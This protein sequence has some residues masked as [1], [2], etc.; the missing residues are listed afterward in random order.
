MFDTQ[1]VSETDRRHNFLTPETE[2][3]TKF[4]VG[5][6]V[7]P[8]RVRQAHSGSK[9]PLTSQNVNAKQSTKVVSS[10]RFI[11]I[12]HIFRQEGEK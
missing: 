3:S 11:S 2:I 10:V 7:A 5:Q 1:T 12:S 6:N 8:W 4:D 9:S